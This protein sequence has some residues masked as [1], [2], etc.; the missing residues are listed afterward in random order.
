LPPPLSP[1]S[2]FKRRWTLGSSCYI[3]WNI[4]LSSVPQTPCRVVLLFRAS[5]KNNRLVYTMYTK[6]LLGF[7]PFQRSKDHRSPLLPGLPHLARS[8][9]RVSH[10]LDGL[11]LLCPLRPSF[12]PVALLGFPS[13]PHS[14]YVPSTARTNRMPGLSPPRRSPSSRWQPLTAASSY[15]LLGSLDV[16][17]LK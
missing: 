13:R 1:F 9:L 8:A 2:P 17:L 11:L 5:P 3:Q 4:L 6:L 10:P 7:R 15:G 12:M 16:N 14:L